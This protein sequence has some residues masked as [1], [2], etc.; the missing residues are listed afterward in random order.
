MSAILLASL[1]LAIQEAPLQRPPP[2]TADLPS[3]SRT[4]TA[5][6]MQAAYPSE[7][8]KT[9]YAASATLECTVAAD[10]GLT[11]C[12][13]ANEDAPG[14][15]A[16]ALTV[17]PKFR[18]P[19][20][21][22]SGVSTVG[23]TVRFP[24]LWVNPSTASASVTAPSDGGPRGAAAISCRVRASRSLDNCVVVD[25]IP[26]GNG[27]LSR[28]KEAALRFRAPASSAEFSRI[29]VSVAVR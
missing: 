9:N 1:L 28:A 6:E 27:A 26:P 21:S 11:D 3:W 14:F 20:K 10:G 2:S 25:A 7:A 13:A 4:P 15:G 18:L 24:I 19:T 12:V 29:L 22:P 23:R 5:A 17:A 8:A 16:A